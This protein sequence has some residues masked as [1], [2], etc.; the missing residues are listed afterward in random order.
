MKKREPV[1]K[2]DNLIYFPELEKRLTEK[3]LES[4][5]TKKYK[6]A[7]QFLEEASALDPE[8]GD[9]LAGL[10]IAYFEGAHYTK[11]K[12]LAKE[13]LHM[14]IGDYFQ[15]VDL[16]LAILLQLQEY[17]EIVSTL[18]ILLDEK[19]IPAEKKEH[20]VTILKFSR[21]MAENSLPIEEV[22]GPRAEA[23]QQQLDLFT[24]KDPNEQ[25]MLISNLADKNI[26][27]FLQEIK[28]YLRSVSGHPFLK[29]LLLNLLKDQG[30]S[31]PFTVHKFNIE[32]SYIPAE[33]P[34]IS[35]QPRMNTIVE[36][37]KGRLENSDPILFENIKSL[38]ERHFLITYPVQL[39]PQDPRAWAAAFHF[40]ALEYY[41][42]KP[43][44]SQFSKEYG[45]SLKE[46]EKAAALIR[47]VEEISYPI[48]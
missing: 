9:I 46:L 11:A 28:D 44:T 36:H 29:T 2:K 38:I 22:A 14:G 34:D 5:Q 45:V 18:E 21:R 13:M 3:G 32:N 12:E 23:Y 35:L 16:Y 27:P 39:E 20:F 6:E 24:V 25:M 41:G 19:E 40:I 15:M 47:E 37:V 7:I 42:S 10:V 33:L 31:Q 4:L 43:R 26:R 48:I 1:K 17:H 8:N 30:F